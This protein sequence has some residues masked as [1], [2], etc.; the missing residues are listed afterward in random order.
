MG[1]S[2]EAGQ[3]NSNG[4]ARRSPRLNSVAIAIAD[5]R[6]SL[7]GMTVASSSENCRAAGFGFG[8]GAFPN[9]RRRNLYTYK[10]A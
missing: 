3:D 9:Y 6:R 4:G 1:F 10:E 2:L 8:F 5:A 7:A